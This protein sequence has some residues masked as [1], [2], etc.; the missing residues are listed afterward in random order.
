M[1]SRAGRA[2]ISTTIETVNGKIVEKIKQTQCILAALG[3]I[4]ANLH[5]TARAMTGKKATDAMKLLDI[6]HINIIVDEIT[7]LENDYNLAVIEVL[8]EYY[9]NYRGGVDRPESYYRIITGEN[10]SVKV[11]DVISKAKSSA[12]LLF[13]VLGTG[14][15]VKSVAKGI[16][17]R[18]DDIIK[19]LDNIHRVSIEVPIEKYNH[20]ICKCGV[21]MDVFPELSELHCP[22]PL[23]GEIRAIVGAVFRD[24]QFYPQDGQKTKH[25]GYDTSRH[26]RFWIERIQGAENKTFEQD[27]LDK[28]EY[29]LNRDKYNKN[30]LTCENIRTIL[31]D[32]SVNLTTLNNHATLLVKIFGGQ[33]PPKLTFQE[34]RLVAIRFNKAM[35]L[36]DI[37]VPSG[38][39]KPYYP[40]FIYKIIEHE[41]RNNPE[42]LRLLD[43]IHL[44]SRET[45][46]KNDKI[47]EQMCELADDEDGL[48]Y[49]P[50]I[51]GGR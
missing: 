11:N 42:K 45:V 6:I 16:E 39:N 33:A 23:C 30:I 20:E 46:I 10:F 31:K 44:Q 26:Y 36:Y 15:L 4:R 7:T 28:I 18:L 40:Y 47:Y 21:R 35:G 34:N 12:H 22:N 27:Q 3:E 37:V 13:R 50:T 24:D 38:G 29:V 19:R 2:S 9:T 1:E 14:F 8:S 43:F 48:V 25:G 49:T 5:E 32:S 17:Y 51:P 41:F